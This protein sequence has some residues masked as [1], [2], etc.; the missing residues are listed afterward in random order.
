MADFGFVYVLHSPRMPGLYKIGATSRSPHQR[1]RE[2]SAVTGVPEEY[3]VAF[4]IET[5]GHHKAEVAAH[6][7]LDRYRLNNRREFFELPLI[8]I[9]NVLEGDG[10]HVSSWDSDMAVEARYPGRLSPF[11]PLW[12]EVPLHEPSY[13]A[14]LSRSIK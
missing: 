9:I 10:E 12:F 1:A 6:R 2:V 13:L 8:E 7:K 4:Y 3:L 11:N 5:A 14:S